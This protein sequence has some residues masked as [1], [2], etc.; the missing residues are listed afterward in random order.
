MMRSVIVTAVLLFAITASAGPSDKIVKA[1][2]KRFQ[3]GNE[4][5]DKGEYQQ[6]LL[7]YQA[8][9]QLLPSPDMLFNIGLAK[10]KTLDYVGCV[11]D[12]EQYLA[13]GGTDVEQARTHATFCR[14]KVKITVTITSVPDGVR[15]SQV[16]GEDPII[17]GRTPTTVEL[18]PGA[19]DLILDKQEYVTQTEHLEVDI[20]K[21][22]AYDFPLE[23]YATLRVDTGNVRGAMVQ[24]NDDPPEPAPVERVRTVRSGSY[25]IRVTAPGHA[26]I[27][28]TRTIAVGQDVQ[29]SLPPE[30]LP[31]RQ[32]LRVTSLAPAMILIDGTPP[33]DTELAAGVHLVEASAHGRVSFKGQIV[34]PAG[35]DIE[36]LVHLPPTRSKLQRGLLWG[37]AGAAALFAIGGGIYGGFALDAEAEYKDMPS[38]E[39]R[40]N[41]LAFRFASDFLLGSA[42]VV[43]AAT[44]IY[45][46]FTRPH[47]ARL[48]VQR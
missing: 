19:Y 30:P 25:R 48:E 44:A 42:I 9:Y 45:W 37:G 38:R 12:L 8:A 10:E 21:P 14:S 4:L 28:Q 40:D 22:R 1:A 29:L 6:A 13:S 43:G 18:T 15:V 26:E 31:T 32:R 11:E 27:D 34:L 3:R 16:T 20:G 41:G 46:Y 39:T 35:K 17:L 24:I 23:Q 36:A 5:Y 2:T 7:N 33:D 47:A